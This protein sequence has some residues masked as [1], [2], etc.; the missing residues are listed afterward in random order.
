MRLF[1]GSAGWA[2]GQLDDELEEGAW[3]VLDAEAGDISTSQPDR[4]WGE[5]LRRQHGEV[6]WFA[7]H[8]DDP[9][10]N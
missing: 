4:L 2:P 6:A 8:P 5:V 3:W 10:A 7:N 1:A 9:S